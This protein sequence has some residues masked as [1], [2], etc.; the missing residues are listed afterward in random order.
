MVHPDQ[1]VV[2]PFAPGDADD[3]GVLA[4]SGTS[5]LLPEVPSGASEVLE[6]TSGVGL[7]AFS[8]PS[9]RVCVHGSSL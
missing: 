4:G 1:Q 2:I 3:A 9:F 8:F 7:R 6:S 5:P